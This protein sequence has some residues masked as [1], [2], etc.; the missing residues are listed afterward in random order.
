MLTAGQVSKAPIW[1]I[2]LLPIGINVQLMLLGSTKLAVVLVWILALVY[3]ADT[4]SMLPD[5]A[6]ITLYKHVSGALRRSVRRV[7][8][9]TQWWARII[10]LSTYAPC[11]AI[12]FYRLF[13]IVCCSSSLLHGLDRVCDMG[14]FTPT[15]RFAHIFTAGQRMR[16]RC[17]LLCGVCWC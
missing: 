17:F 12:I 11:N 6:A 10:L 16:C 1:T 4:S 3:Y 8:C 15:R 5:T 14:T 9:F 2:F 7:E 13:I